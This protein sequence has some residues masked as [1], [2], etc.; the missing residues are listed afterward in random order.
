MSIRLKILIPTIALTILLAA[1]ILVSN[2]IQF[3]RFVDNDLNNY[4]DN[5]ATRTAF[6]EID[7]LKSE[8]HVSSLYI[9]G[10]N[11]VARLLENGDRDALVE[12]T[13][14]LV[15]NVGV[16]FCTI[17]D[18][19]GN[20]FARSHAPDAYGDDIN[21]T[22]S[23][24]AALSGNTSS[25]IQVG[26]AIRLSV[27][28]GA[29]I[30]NSNGD[31]LG[32]AL[33]GFRLDTHDFVDALKERLDCEITIFHGDERIATTV[34]H[35]NGDR[36]T[37]TKAMTDISS[38]VLGGGVYSGLASVQNRDALARYHPI[39]TD[40]GEVIGM[41]FV[42][43]YLAEK[44][45][46]VRDFI[47]FGLLITLVAVVVCA[48][49]A[50][51]LSSWITRKI[52]FYEYILDS[53]PYPITVT[54]MDRK[55]TFINKAVEDFLGK[56]RAE[57]KGKKCSEW[58]AAICNTK[59]CGIN[60]LERGEPET[61]FE[62]GGMDF[63]V[64]VSYSKD[65]KGNNAGHIEFVRDISDSLRVRKHE[66]EVVGQISSISDSVATVSR[67]IA[68]NSQSLAQGS[69]QQ[70]AAVE[71][72]SSAISE[73]ACMTQENADMA[74]R[75][76][77]LAGIIKDNAEKGSG[78]MDSMT[79]AIEEINQASQNI[80]R[81]IKVI[82]DIAF[83][84]N[85]L[86]LNAAVEAARAGQH[87]KGFAVVA[88]EVRSL[89]SKSA[90]AAK[91]TGDLITNSIEKAEVGAKI[92]TATASDLMEIV[93]GINES[94]RIASEIAVSSEHQAHSIE[95]INVSIDQVAEIVRQNSMNAEQ[96]AATSEELSSQS[97]LLIEMISRIDH[98]AELMQ[99]FGI[100]A[101]AT[102]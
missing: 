17:T 46:T 21:D 100:A 88:E 102:A 99:Q 77:A 37:G 89:A 7:M 65:K 27:T 6:D 35:E 81:V 28:A 38:T 39:V 45:N 62:Q 32:V 84:T 73:I 42:G 19:S 29:P 94:H 40:D 72:L 69:T 64:T 48:I 24:T 86:A 33:S 95:G 3:D 76:A 60:C 80:S 26:S 56:T 30:Y 79:A 44:T 25:M 12:R 15:E 58:G 8:A 74:G 75:A 85:I 101:N 16:E 93:S 90:A 9:A 55:W 41:L 18:V 4:L 31:L 53:I 82:D 78:H 57:V 10:D 83:Q 13:R 14:Q 5:V 66:M 63:H 47:E 70:A 34:R 91:D 54:D 36:A 68:A 92:A 2:I 11:E 71:E 59:K 22:K 98:E 61:W 23:V 52:Y 97:G 87:G 67:S 43:I 51:L 20:A 96:S 1:A 49:L 50:L